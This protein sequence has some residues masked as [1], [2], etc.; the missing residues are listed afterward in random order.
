MS[1]KG[2]RESTIAISAIVGSVAIAVGIALF[3]E[4]HSGDAP[5]PG[6][7]ATTPESS[8]RSGDMP[9]TLPTRATTELTSA[10]SFFEIAS[11]PDTPAFNRTR[12][13]VDAGEVVSITFRN[14]SRGSDRHSL[15]IVQ[16]G[17]EEEV[18]AAAVEAGPEVGFLPNSQL[19]VARTDM[20]APGESETIVFRVPTQPGNYPFI[21]TYPGHW[22]TMRGELEVR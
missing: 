16:P 17:S 19:I 13:E 14:V 2:V 8:A 1:R 18:A 21:C 10:T 15:V 22:H 9:G 3:S 20:L 6:G 11:D 12:L 4:R 5:G 7:V